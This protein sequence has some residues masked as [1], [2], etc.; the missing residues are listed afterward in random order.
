MNEREEKELERL[1]GRELK[2]L[3]DL[4][5][6]ETLLHRV[7]LNV[8]ARER[9]AWWRR[10]WLNWPRPARLVSVTLSVG[11]IAALTYFGSMAWQAAGIGNPLDRIWQ[12]VI[13][14]APAWNWLAS[15]V[16]ALVLVLQ[17]GG[18][19]YLLIGLSL[20]ATMYLLCIATGTA[21][22]RLAFNRR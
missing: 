2:N 15:L 7:M 21:C 16:N 1:I 22:Y 11:A 20:A 8:H 6:P 10:P 3:A 17:H 12:W 19:R 9:L 13:S 18:Q 14:L 5:A 4:R